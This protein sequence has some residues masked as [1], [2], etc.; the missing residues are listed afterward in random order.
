MEL[1]PEV[2]QFFVSVDVH[3]A[4]DDLGFDFEQANTTT[5]IMKIVMM[6]MTT[7]ITTTTMMM[8]MTAM[9]MIMSIYL[10]SR[11]TCNRRSR[12]TRSQDSSSAKA[13]LGRYCSC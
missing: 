7:T 12:V 8:M 2:F 1:P 13:G 5:K 3:E 6:M 10:S 9:M 4:R 11:R